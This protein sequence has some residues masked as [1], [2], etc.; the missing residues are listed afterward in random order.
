MRELGLQLEPVQQL[1]S[2]E[3]LC[4]MG[5]STQQVTAP[6]PADDR[7]PPD[8][9]S[10]RILAPADE[11]S[12]SGGDPDADAPLLLSN[13]SSSRSTAA[14][15]SAALLNLKQSEAEGE[16]A[17]AQLEW[18]APPD[19]NGGH[20]LHYEL[21]IEL[22]I[23]GVQGSLEVRCAHLR[24]SF[25]PTAQQSVHLSHRIE[26]TAQYSFPYSSQAIRNA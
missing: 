3:E 14:S 8:S 4:S 2:Y 26:C 21:H 9:F 12:G 15:S 17:F 10:A 11:H 25:P 6:T 20:V 24:S 1:V 23:D 5:A 13:G 18:S 22:A 16:T 7:I 19:P